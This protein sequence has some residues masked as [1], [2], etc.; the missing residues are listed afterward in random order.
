[1][2]KERKTHQ[3][4]M[5]LLCG[6]CLR[7]EKNLININ[8]DILHLIKQHHH[9]SYDLSLMPTVVCKSCMRPLR[10]N[11]TQYVRVSSYGYKKGSSVADCFVISV[12][13]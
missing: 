8:D 9:P 5:R 10:A 2:P 11:I 13:L 3:D 12:Y 1:M 6:V 7:K 4:W